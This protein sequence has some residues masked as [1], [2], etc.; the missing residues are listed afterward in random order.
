MLLVIPRTLRYH[1]A[2]AKI[3][4]IFIRNPIVL[5]ILLSPM[6]INW[7]SLFLISFLS[8]KKFALYNVSRKDEFSPLKNATGSDS[9]ATSR[10]DLMNLYI[11]YLRPVGNPPILML[12]WKQYVTNVL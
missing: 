11:K 4:G 12:M 6:D 10:R 7:S 9:P 2:K 8:S 1:V 3:S 5:L